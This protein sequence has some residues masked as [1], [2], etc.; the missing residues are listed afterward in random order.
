MTARVIA[1]YLPQ[2]HPIPENDKFW[3]KG[4]T[5]WTNV[6]KAKPLFRGHHQPNI[7]ADL[8]F[9]D[10][11]MKEVREKQAILAKEAG[12][13]GFCY[14]HYWFGDGKELLESIF[15]EVVDSD[16]PDFPFC[17]GWANHSWTTKTWAKGKGTTEQT[18]IAEQMYLGE[19]DHILHFNKYL[20]AFKDK[21]YITVDGKL[22]FVIFSPLAFENFQEFKT[23]WNRLA[24]ENGLPGFHFVGIGRNFAVTNAKTK[25]KI[26][27]KKEIDAAAKSYY[28]EVLNIGYDA[29]QSRGDVRACL[30]SSSFLSFY[31]KRF[32]Q[33]IGIKTIIKFKYS[34]IIDHYFAK[35]DSWENVYPTIIP[36]FDRSP[37]AGWNTNNLWYG[38]TPKLFKKHVEKALDLLKN[39]NEEHKILF[40]QSWNEWGEGNYMEPDLQ[41]GH[42]YLD[43]LREVLTRK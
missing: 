17:L 21:R 4:F 30:L 27:S 1:Y 9:Y 14:W 33:K 36:N 28:S 5:E 12:I 26:P 23:C 40:L 7:P 2:Y 25:N 20:K 16:E 34:E 15:N 10:L 22:L 41:F 29:V 19:Q 11:R 43:A 42:G 32:L 39:K 38:S 18:M 3:G 35:E 24:I 8:G 13:E 31:F 6:A 37:R